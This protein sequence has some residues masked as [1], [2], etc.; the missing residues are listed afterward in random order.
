MLLLPLC[1]LYGSFQ[2]LLC[3]KLLRDLTGFVS[4]LTSVFVSFADDMRTGMDVR[5]SS[6]SPSS[7]P[8]G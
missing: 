6:A 1:K 3:T 4:W 2:K 7:V 8:S 5:H